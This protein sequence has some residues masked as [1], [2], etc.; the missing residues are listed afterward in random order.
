MGHGHDLGDEQGPDH[1]TSRSPDGIR[2]PTPPGRPI[3]PGRGAYI[4]APRAPPSDSLSSRRFGATE[5]ALPRGRFMLIWAGFVQ[6][7][8]DKLWKTWDK[9]ARTPSGTP[10][11]RRMVRTIRSGSCPLRARSR[12]SQAQ[13]EIFLTLV[14]PVPSPGQGVQPRGSGVRGT[15]CGSRELDPAR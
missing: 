10:D 7:G 14:R 9:Y 5:F 3:H 8:V 6:F 4:P 13:R 12:S 2:P 15:P 11:D 1:R